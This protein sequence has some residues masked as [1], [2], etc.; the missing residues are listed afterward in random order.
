[1]IP[2]NLH[3]PLSSPGDRRPQFSLLTL[4]IA[5]TAVA[6][7]CGLITT[8]SP[9]WSAAILWILVLIAAHVAGN[10]Q[11]TTMRQKHSRQVDVPEKPTSSGKLVYAPT[12]GLRRHAVLGRPMFVSAAASA[13]A[14]CIVGV[15]YLTGQ[16]QTSSLPGL[17]LG[18]SSAG[19]IGGLFGFLSSSFFTVAAQSFREAWQGRESSCSRKR[20]DPSP[21]DGRD[22]RRAEPP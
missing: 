7:F 5:V 14:G 11:G 10:W 18:A 12:T 8:V 3:S 15:I 13:V 16:S 1:M 4:F 9:L 19:I 6:G 2:E 20:T 21:M 17:V 22:E